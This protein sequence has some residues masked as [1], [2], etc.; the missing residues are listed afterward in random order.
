MTAINIHFFEVINS[1]SNIDSKSN[2]KVLIQ[3]IKNLF[4][5]KIYF[6]QP[7]NLATGYSLLYDQHYLLTQ[8]YFTNRSDTVVVSN[9]R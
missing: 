2:C 1:C 6:L 5:S 7:L 9:A 3:T 4:I 8:N